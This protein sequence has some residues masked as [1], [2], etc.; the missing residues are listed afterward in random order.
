MNGWYA[1]LRILNLIIFVAYE[2]IMFAVRL[3]E[4]LEIVTCGGCDATHNQ[5]I[6]L[7]EW[8]VL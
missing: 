5:H 3:L 8:D 4:H 2:R 7:S 1:T 6:D